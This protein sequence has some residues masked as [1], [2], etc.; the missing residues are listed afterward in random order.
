MLFIKEQQINRKN[1]VDIEK[2]YDG[3]NISFT[4]HSVIHARK[5]SLLPRVDRVFI[6]SPIEPFLCLVSSLIHLATLHRGSFVIIQPC[7]WLF[8]EP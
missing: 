4:V 5:I 6:Q 1:Y 7:R 2:D 3:S 8:V